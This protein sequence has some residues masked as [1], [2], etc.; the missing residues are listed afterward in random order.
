MG[1]K[2]EEEVNRQDA[3]SAK[4]K[5]MGEEVNHREHRGRRGR[6][7]TGRRLAGSVDQ[8]TGLTG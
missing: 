2:N 6:R 4:K 7:R 8:M 1:K 5:K 3:K